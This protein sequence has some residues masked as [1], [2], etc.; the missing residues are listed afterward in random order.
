MSSAWMKI[1][2]KPAIT[3]SAEG[4]RPSSS[5]FLALSTHVERTSRSGAGTPTSSLPYGDVRAAG[6]LAHASIQ[7]YE[8]FPGDIPWMSSALLRWRGACGSASLV[9]AL[10]IA[11][12]SGGATATI[13]LNE[14][15]RASRDEIFKAATR[16]S[17]K[18]D[19]DRRIH[20]RPADVPRARLRPAREV[21]GRARPH[22]PA[23]QRHDPARALRPRP[24][25]DLGAV[26]PARP[27]GQ[28]QKLERRVL[29]AGKDQRRVH[30]TAPSSAASKARWNSPPK[31][32]SRKS[33]RA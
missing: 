2:V 13:A 14:V 19:R 26:D 30:A 33:S 12:L 23:A 17:S 25:T 11:A 5:R 15:E 6:G 27:A 4:T 24:G 29:P 18:P 20:G 28:H 9:A 32:S 10:L 3:S 22:R 7:P 8:L 16:S 31:R 21:Q 1:A